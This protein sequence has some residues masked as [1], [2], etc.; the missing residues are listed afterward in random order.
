M[1]TTTVVT[2]IF[3]Y[4]FPGALCVYVSDAKGGQHCLWRRQMEL[5]ADIAQ[6]A[7]QLRRTVMNLL[8]DNITL[9]VANG[10]T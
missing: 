6:V 1:Q 7:D 8:R 10:R 9:S 4:D 2:V 3:P 5:D